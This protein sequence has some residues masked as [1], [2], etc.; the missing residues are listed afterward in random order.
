[1]SRD[2]VFFR[3]LA[4]VHPRFGT[5]AFAIVACS[6]WAMCLAA[7]GS[8]EQL[9]TYVVFVGWIFYALGGLAI[10]TYRRRQPNAIRPFKVPGYPVTPILFVASALAVV[11]N[12]VVTQPGRA[13]LGLIVTV[14]GVPVFFVWR[15]N[16]TRA[17]RRRGDV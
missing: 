7:T 17:N 2:G 12:T 6:V 14:V 3:K 4:E 8:F 15:A 11:V 9:F 5:P 10:F 16:R 1:M 13:A